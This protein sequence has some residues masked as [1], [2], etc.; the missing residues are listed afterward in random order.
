MIQNGIGI[1]DAVAA[2]FPQNKLISAVAYIGASRPTSGV[3]LHEGAG[4]LQMGSFPAGK[5]FPEAEVLVKAFQLSG[6]PCEW[7]DDIQLLRWKKLLWNISYNT[8]SVLGGGLHTRQ[9]LKADGAGALCAGLMRETVAVAQ[10][11]GVALKISDAQKQIDYNETFPAYKTSMLQDYLAGKPLEVE[12]IVGNAFR[13]AQQHHVDVPGITFCYH[14]L[15][16]VDRMNPN[17]KA[18]KN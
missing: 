17:K 2:A 6:V 18:N 1:E 12:A 15:S 16:S 7:S 9:M 10:S 11:C 13:L 14:L 5:I 3:V 8:I 4:N